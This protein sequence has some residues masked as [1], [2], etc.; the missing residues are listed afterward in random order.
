MKTALQLFSVRDACKTK[1]DFL[2]TLKEV[3]KQGYDGVEF[4]G[5]HGLTAPELKA[6]L[7]ELELTP[8]ASHESLDRLENELD[9]VLEY[10]RGIGNRNIVCA[11]SPADSEE[12]LQR[13]RR[14]LQSAQKA[15]KKYEMNV[16]YHNH[17]HELVP[18][19]GKIPLEVIKE[20]CMLELD[21]YWLFNAKIDVCSYMKANASRIGLIHLKDGGLNADPCTIGE[22]KNDI[23]GIIDTAREI[24]REWL[25]VENDNPKPDGLSDSARSINNL[26]TKYRI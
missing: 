18:V 22:G 5:Y 26:K 10:S 15:A 6:A 8:V 9:D 2:R 4:A 3:K 24:D 20:Y 25:I 16:F 14:V 23:Q 19:N 17:S 12:N 11:Y 7:Q 13:L 21:T 1:E